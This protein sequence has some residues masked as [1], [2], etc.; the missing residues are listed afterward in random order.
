MSVNWSTPTASCPQDKMGALMRQRRWLKVALYLA[1]WPVAAFLFA[2]QHYLGRGPDEQTIG[3][4]RVITSQL[5]QWYAW[6][7]VF[8]F[9]FW[10]ARRFPL[11]SPRLASRLRVH[12]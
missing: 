9:I 3:W 4:R 7:A 1:G 2:I 6:A 11:E 8:P 10:L 5:G 12:I